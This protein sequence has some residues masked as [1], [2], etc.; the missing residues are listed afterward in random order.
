MRVAL[1]LVAIVASSGS[2]PTAG[3]LDPG[4]SLG[5][6]HLGETQAQVRSALGR[7]YGVCDTCT[8]PTWYF[9]YGKWTQTGLAV[10]LARGVVS[11]V[12]T[13]WQPLGWHSSHG[14]ALGAPRGQVAAV[15]GP[16]V[17]IA[18]PGYDALVRDV[19]G[20]RT[21]YYIVDDKLW[22]FGLM[23]ARANPCRT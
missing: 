4:R 17:P 16:V 7:F 21:V 15:A 2:L 20:T 8:R 9:T 22:G 19:R 11:A 13:L 23:K 5:G 1:A 18:C 10:E 12:Y 14:L 3:T 6:I